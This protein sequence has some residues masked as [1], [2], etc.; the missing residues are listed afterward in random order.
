MFR[1]FDAVLVED[2]SHH[3]AIIV[4][5]RIKKARSDRMQTV[6]P[7]ARLVDRLG[8]KVGRH[9]LL[10]NFLILKRIMVL[11]KGHRTGI[12]PAVNNFGNTCHQAIALGTADVHLVDHRLVKLNLFGA[13]GR[14]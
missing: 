4:G 9:A 1:H 3:D 7:S 13:V 5:R 11:G 6:K 8:D 14:H 2:V 12:V 10:E